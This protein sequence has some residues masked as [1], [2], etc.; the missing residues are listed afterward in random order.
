MKKLF[1]DSTMV[2]FSV[3][4]NL[5]WFIVDFVVVLGA[6]LVLTLAKITDPLALTFVMILAIFLIAV[7][8][9]D[10]LFR[11]NKI[12]FVHSKEY[13][14]NFPQVKDKFDREMTEELLYKGKKVVVTKSFLFL[15]Q[16]WNVLITQTHHFVIEG[17]RFEGLFYLNEIAIIE[18]K[19]RNVTTPDVIVFQDNK[20][21]RYAMKASREIIEKLKE[22]IPV[23]TFLLNNAYINKNTRKGK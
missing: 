3:K 15:P 13:F 18:V 11:I 1:D 16:V 14:V 20:G 2:R 9:L 10:F 6:V 23:K 8:L 4:Y 22:Y 12:R 7:F 5:L 21:Y 17:S 19:I